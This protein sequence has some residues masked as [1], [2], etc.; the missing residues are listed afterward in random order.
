[1]DIPNPVNQ[2]SENVV[3]PQERRV[4]T[5]TKI[6]GPSEIS[7]GTRETT[8]LAIPTRSGRN[9]WLTYEDPEDPTETAIN[10]W[11][12]TVTIGTDVDPSRDIEI[13]TDPFTVSPQHATINQ[14]PDGYY[15]KNLGPN[16]TTIR[17]FES[18]PPGHNLVPTGQ[19]RYA[20]IDRIPR[21]ILGR[22]AIPITQ[23]R[24]EVYLTINGQK[25][26]ISEGS[27]I[28]LGRNA[29]IPIPVDSVSGNHASLMLV[30]GNI[31]VRDN[32]SKN[33]TFIDVEKN[34]QHN[35]AQPSRA[36]EIPKI[37][38]YETLAMSKTPRFRAF[39]SSGKGCLGVFAGLGEDLF[40]KTAS[41]LAEDTIHNTLEKCSDNPSQDELERAFRN[42]WS[43]TQARIALKAETDPKLKEMGTTAAVAKL[44]KDGR[45]V[46][47]A[48][49]GDSLLYVIKKDGSIRRITEPQNTIPRQGLFRQLAAPD[50]IKGHRM[51]WNGKN[52]PSHYISRDM[53]EPTI[54]IYNI[55]PNDAVLLAGSYEISSLIASK[56]NLLKLLAD[57]SAPLKNSIETLTETKDRLALA[58]IRL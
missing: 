54:G 43:G 25:V 30:D 45:I 3:P 1:M 42:G 26:K 18:C 20:P 50:E 12:N 52:P 38:V 24:G 37:K 29:K 46:H 34:A 13:T 57:Q 40:A 47:Y 49:S 16:S 7:V 5:P 17:T 36:P 10:T 31:Y 8:L 28:K 2:A 48:Y 55:E 39:A 21:I 11:G 56:D 27:I 41:T 35:D 44:S 32:G 6:I 14:E 15:I 22:T 9:I 51:H 58:A 33:R 23:E 4:T 19:W 53:A